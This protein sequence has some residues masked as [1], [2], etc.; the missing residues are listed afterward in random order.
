MTQ[1]DKSKYFLTGAV[2]RHLKISPPQNQA[3]FSLHPLHPRL[4]AS[5]N[6][7]TQQ[8]SISYRPLKKA[9]QHQLFLP[10]MDALQVW[11]SIHSDY[12]I[13]VKGFSTSWRC[14]AV[15]HSGHSQQPPSSPLTWGFSFLN[16]TQQKTCYNVRSV[17]DLWSPQPG[18][19][20]Q[21]RTHWCVALYF[22]FYINTWWTHAHFC[23]GPS[24]TQEIFS[25]GNF[26]QSC[27][28]W[29]LF[30][31]KANVHGVYIT[32]IN[33]QLASTRSGDA[34]SEFFLLRAEVMGSLWLSFFPTVCGK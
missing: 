15:K 8:F 9:F 22:E 17:C 31:M 5:W 21:T 18:A 25:R 32:M 1:G 11:R 3:I 14:P 23:F 20:I 24:S 6:T 28:P 13:G 30:W 10:V 7:F 26:R 4:L 33:Q 16:N 27:I 29:H 12:T 19:N 2:L 34:V